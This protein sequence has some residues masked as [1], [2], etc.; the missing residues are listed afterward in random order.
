MAHLIH[1]SPRGSRA[2]SSD[3][4][5][6]VDSVR[7]RICRGRL[8]V[9]SGLHLSKHDT[10][11]ETYMEEY[12]LTP[13]E[14]IAKDFRIIQSSRLGYFPHGKRDWIAAIKEV[15]KRERNITAKYLRQKYPHLYVQGVWIFGDWDKALRAAGFDPERTRIRSSGDEE[16]IVKEIRAMRRENLPLNAHYVLKHRPKLFSAAVRHFGSWSNALVAAGIIKKRFLSKLFT[17][18]LAILRA[19]RGILESRSKSDIPQVLRFQAELYF[20]SLRIAIIVLKKD[21]RL[22]SGWSKPKILKILSRMHR[23][24]VGLAY[25]KV[26][27]EFP[28]LVSAAE[29][30]FGS[31]GK[32]LYAAGIDPNLY[33]VHHTWRKA[34]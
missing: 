4:N 32:A 12:G 33:F 6:G 18:R 15:Y 24:K 9:I 8:R 23:A 7:C 16:R 31:W 30:Y 28:A 27:R 17:S 22:L 1:R 26:R 11:R 25:A 2:R 29:A 10:D 20:G 21:Q 34:A 5:D 14:L 13:D 19:I 3:S